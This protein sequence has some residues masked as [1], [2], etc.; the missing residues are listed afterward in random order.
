MEN[1][2]ESQISKVWKVSTEVNVYFETIIKELNLTYL[3]I[4]NQL[5]TH[6]QLKA[7][8]KDKHLKRIV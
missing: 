6:D 2:F 4:K 1:T 3:V 7:K 8:L 5:L